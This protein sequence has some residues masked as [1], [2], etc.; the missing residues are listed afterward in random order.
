MNNLSFLKFIY[1]VLFYALMSLWISA[2]MV[3]LSFVINKEVRVLAFL[4][5]SIILLLFF[6]YARMK[7]KGK[8]LNRF[9]DE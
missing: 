6:S 9:R 4:I 1:N 7:L 8:I 2:V 3:L 5:V